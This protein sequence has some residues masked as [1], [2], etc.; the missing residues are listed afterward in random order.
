MIHNKTQMEMTKR[1]TAS[2]FGHAEKE[3]K[4]KDKK[5]YQDIILI[6][7][8]FKLLVQIQMEIFMW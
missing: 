5:E 6:F 2:V 1:N 4:E 7:N 3:T 8:K